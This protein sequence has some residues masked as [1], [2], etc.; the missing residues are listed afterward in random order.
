MDNG[1]WLGEG[2]GFVELLEIVVF[3]GHG[4]FCPVGGETIYRREKV[5]IFR[6][7]VEVEEKVY[8]NWELIIGYAELK[9]ENW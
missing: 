6:L 5:F 9:V 1:G 8:D 3:L 4:V 2:N 7:V